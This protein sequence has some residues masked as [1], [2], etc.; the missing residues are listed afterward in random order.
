MR[1]LVLAAFA[2][3][4]SS[5]KPLPPPPPLAAEKAAVAPALPTAAAV[6]KTVRRS[7]TCFGTPCGTS[8][9]TFAADGTIH[10]VLDVHDNGR[11]PHTDS[12]IK[13][14]PDGTLASFEA[15]GHGTFGAPSNETFT[16][17]G[18]HAKWDSQ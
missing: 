3:A 15:H 11:G 17:A 2:V 1:T 13:L 8:V 6:T 4:C 7:I 14:A 9:M 12:T 10:D 16:L 5:S 18:G